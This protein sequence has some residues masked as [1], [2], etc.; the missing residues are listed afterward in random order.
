MNLAISRYI[1]FYYPWLV[2]VCYRSQ[3]TLTTC[4][5]PRVMFWQQLPQFHPPKLLDQR[6][7]E[8][9]K[10]V[11]DYWFLKSPTKSSNQI[12]S[13][14]FLSLIAFYPQNKSFFLSCFNVPCLDLGHTH[15]RHC[16]YARMDKMI[17]AGATFENKMLLVIF[18]YF[19]LAH[20]SSVELPMK[21]H[22]SAPTRGMP[23]WL[24]CIIPMIEKCKLS[25]S[26]Q[27]S[28][29][30]WAVHLPDPKTYKSREGLLHTWT[31]W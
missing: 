29:S 9:R 17:Q 23:N 19:Y 27:L 14:N 25:H 24:N 26:D 5:L 7:N 3:N 2:I 12:K 18:S 10:S 31:T 21:P 6:N 20:S 16:G 15:P 11:S 22:M 13:E 4:T 30:Q 28:P 8:T 1:S